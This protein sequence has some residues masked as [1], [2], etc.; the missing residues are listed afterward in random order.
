MT[1]P[2]TRHAL[3]GLALAALIPLLACAPPVPVPLTP[4]PPADDPPAGGGAPTRWWSVRLQTEDEPAAAHD[5]ASEAALRFDEPVTVVQGGGSWH[6]QVGACTTQE[7][8]RGLATL[9]RARGYRSATV[10]VIPPPEPSADGPALPP[11]P[12]EGL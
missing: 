12:A 10:V 1:L 6:V 8:A 4:S 5:R 3:R 11:D 9:A 7:Q 2:G